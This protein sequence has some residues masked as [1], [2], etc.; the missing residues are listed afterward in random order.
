MALYVLVPATGTAI[1]SDPAGAIT[2]EL[3]ERKDGF[4]A[5]QISELLATVARSHIP[6]VDIDAVIGFAQSM[7]SD[8]PSCWN[9]VDWLGFDEIP[10]VSA[11]LAPLRFVEPYRS[12]RADRNSLRMACSSIA[13]KFFVE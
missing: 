8:L 12:G 9:A 3:I 6:D 4:I 13:S 11:D 5:D 1:G 7:L 10:A 2:D